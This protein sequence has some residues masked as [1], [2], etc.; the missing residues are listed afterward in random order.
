MATVVQEVPCAGGR[1]NYCED[2]PKATPALYVRAQ[3]ARNI[4]ITLPTLRGH[5]GVW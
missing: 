4:N 5:R 2:T 3:S 1:N